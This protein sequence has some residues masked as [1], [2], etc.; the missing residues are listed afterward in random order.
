MNTPLQRIFGSSVRVSIL[1]LLQTDKWKY[2][3]EIQYDIGASSLYG[4]RRE[5]INLVDCNL[6]EKREIGRKHFFR[7]KDNKKMQALTNFLNLY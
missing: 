3:R 5:L 7:L 2:M 4:V 1:R 6:V